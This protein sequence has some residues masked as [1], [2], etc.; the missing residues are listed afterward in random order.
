MTN[1]V[2]DSTAFPI[3]EIAILSDVNIRELDA[4]YVSELM[5]VQIEYGESH[6]QTHWKEKPKINQDGVLFSGF[7]TI[8]A[9]KR[10]FGNDHEV[11]FQV[12]EGDP[13]LLA[14]CENASHGKR[15]TN[16]DKRVAVL[17]WLQD[18]EGRQW[19][20]SHIAKQCYVS[21]FLVNSVD[22]LL[23]ENGS[24]TYDR[25]T[26]RK[27]IDKHGNVTWMETAKINDATSTAEVVIA[28]EKSASEVL[29][30]QEAETLLK[31]KRRKL[32]A[33]WDARSQA[34]TDYVGEDDTAL[35]H[36]G[37]TL[38]Q[39][40][41]GF[42]LS[43]PA[44]ADAF[45]S[46]ME[47]ARSGE[48]F[49][50][51]F[52]ESVL[53][54]DTSLEDLEKECKAISIYA[55][56]I[57]T[58]QEQDW[59]QQI[60]RLKSDRIKAQDANTEM[61]NAFEKSDLS[62]HLDKD[63][64]QEVASK[65]LQCPKKFPDPMQMK[66]PEI[67]VCWFG[68]ITRTI[69]QESGWVKELLDEFREDERLENDADAEKEKQSE[70]EKAEKELEEARKEVQASRWDMWRARD[71]TGLTSHST[72]GVFQIAA[73]KSLGLSE[74]AEQYMY[75]SVKDPL[76]DLPLSGLR[77]WR[78]RFDTLKI[79]IEQK[80]EW[81][82]ALYPQPDLEGLKA[83]LNDKHWR[84]EHNWGS[85]TPADMNALAEKYH[86]TLAHV[87]EAKKEVARENPPPDWEGLEV[88][89][90]SAEISSGTYDLFT[91]AKK[92]HMGPLDSVA[93]MDLQKKVVEQLKSAEVEEPDYEQTQSEHTERLK[94]LPGEIRD[95]IPK[96]QEAHAIEGEITLKFLLNARC[97][98]EYGRE[99]GPDPFFK[100]EMQDLLDSMKSND[101]ALVK[102]VRELLGGKPEVGWKEIRAALPEWRKRN[103]E[104]ADVNEDILLQAANDWHYRKEEERQSPASAEELKGLLELIEEDVFSFVVRVREILKGDDTLK[105]ELPESKIDKDQWIRI[106]IETGSGRSS[107]GALG[108]SPSKKWLSRAVHIGE[109]TSDDI[110][111]I[112]DEMLDDLKHGLDALDISVDEDE[113]NQDV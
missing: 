88:A 73:L 37:L 110:E 5:Q 82:K 92:H 31:K 20:D 26:K 95:Y 80:A 65:A 63:D 61:W 66:R 111:A 81:V 1:T 74:D 15:R 45:Q 97:Q 60:I 90:R 41:E 104:V 100:E 71:E 79:G 77:T 4:D 93:V 42:P 44:I 13:Y 16:A 19:T 17:R 75:E 6:W 10:N 87:R 53:E 38:E 28:G 57:S 56:D 72:P 32:K 27:Y 2:S 67:W 70:A 83:A 9:A 51:K 94:A 91:L 62:K 40:Q 3:S 58:W 106:V 101:A 25:P 108:C 78:S 102:K 43:H 76:L 35:Q 54:S 18:N 8:T 50:E 21:D 29:K 36:Q 52:Q 69:E 12:V 22:V 107:D 113:E 103:S 14:A 96:W 49:F 55:H 48:G 59:I 24:D 99:R 39:L 11:S 112:P 109:Y 47:R 89:I 30:E 85:L 68:A 23:Q 34:C 33:L 7:H 84:H 64:L 105:V 98:I 46:G 86:C